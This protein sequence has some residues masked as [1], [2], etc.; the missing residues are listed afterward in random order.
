MNNVFTKENGS[1][2]LKK[3]IYFVSLIAAM[4]IVGYLIAKGGLITATGILIFP[5]LLT[6]IYFIFI[7]P[8]VGIIGL[9]IL[10]YF[11]LGATRYIHG[12][13]LGLI[14]D[15]HLILIY[16]SLFFKSFFHEIP[17]KN[18]RNDLVLLAFVWFV[19]A[20]LQLLNPEAVSRIAWFYAMRGVALYMLL[21]VP[22]I[23]IVFNKRNDLELFFKIWA[24]LSLL[25]TLKG[26]MQKFIGPDPW[27]Q[28]WLNSGG[29]VTH[30]LFGNLRIFSFFSDAGQF[31]AAQGHAG[32]VFL[33]L[34]IHQKKPLKLRIFYGIVGFLALYGMIISGTRGAIA[35]P[36]MGFGLYVLLQ[37][38]I[39]VIL[40][41]AVLGAAILGFFLL[42]TIGDSN[43]TINRMRSAF[44]PED[45]SLQVRL[46]NQQKLK[47]YLTSRPF[48]GGIGS[49]GTWGRNFSPNTFLAQIPTDSWYVMVWAEQGIVGLMLH[50]F[51]LFYIVI[52]SSY[53]IMFRLRNPWVKAQMSALVS[54]MWGIMVASYGN[55][56]LGQMP[57]G[58]IIY[59]S[60]GF[61]FLAQK[62]DNELI[63]NNRDI[64]QK[65]RKPQ[66]R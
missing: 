37:R 2:L 38:N 63:N 11:V 51:I 16:L 5:F 64:K 32:V 62:F 65:T 7:N 56:V 50:L 1:G 48:G 19:F 43:Y 59:S 27:E 44:N 13:P 23:F 20:F 30:V 3:P 35:V 54:G 22:L 46:E 24:V 18:A 14:I 61:L 21:T 10:N 12:V 29:D 49:A 58:I 31:G 47:S 33:I 53:V 6:Y 66:T 34:A 17:W 52:K 26:L 41:G 39:K 36:I 40:S 55:S 42:T 25:G 15:V 45:K 60:M 57:T 9:L 8:R 4:I 28:A